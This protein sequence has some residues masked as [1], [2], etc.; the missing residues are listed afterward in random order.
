MS[1]GPRRD[2]HRPATVP[3]LFEVEDF[4][5]KIYQ[6]PRWHGAEA[7]HVDAGAL[8][9]D[10]RRPH[11]QNLTVGALSGRAAATPAELR[12][13]AGTLAHADDPGGP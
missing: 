13:A 3:V 11:G 4:P 7:V 1:G 5:L 2:V 9:A 6:L 10:C 12:A 8:L